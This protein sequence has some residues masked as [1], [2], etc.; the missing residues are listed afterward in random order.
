[1]DEYILF[2]NIKRLQKRLSGL[3]PLQFRTLA[4]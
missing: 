2:Y 4:A 3:S 1:M